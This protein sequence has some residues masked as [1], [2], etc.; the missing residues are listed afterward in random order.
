MIYL[1]TGTNE[2]RAQQEVNA[3]AKRGGLAPEKIDVD[4]LDANGLSDIVRGAS[5]FSEKRLVVLRQLSERKDLW[6]KLGEWASEL[7]ADT[8]L[9]LLELKPDKRTKTYKT[10]AKTATVIVAEP[11]TERQKPA[12][13]KWLQDLA[14]K[15][16]VELM[17]AQVAH[18][19]SCALIVREG[20]RQAEVDQLQLAHA[21]KALANLKTVTDEAIA[22]VLP[23]AREFSVFDLLELAVRGDTAAVQRAL[24]E[25]RAAEDPYKMMAL[26]WSQWSSLAAARLAGDLSSAQLASDLAIH[27]FVAKKLQILARQLKIA[28]IRDLTRLAAELDY[29]SKVSAVAPWDAVD[30]FILGVATR[31]S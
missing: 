9:V 31:L 10:L 17:P 14:Q 7:N 13:E 19:V 30:R 28:E 25:L 20:P 18:M 4:S 16:G 3:L 15:Q 21:V 6:D 11:L 5:L 1:I 24:N 26:I 23:P 12:A 27:P 2:Y 22:A 8:T 29:Q